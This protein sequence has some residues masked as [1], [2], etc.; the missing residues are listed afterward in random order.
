MKSL[1][2]TYNCWK[3]PMKTSVSHKT[4]FPHGQDITAST[5]SWTINNYNY[6]W[7]DCWCRFWLWQ[8]QHFRVLDSCSWAIDFGQKPPDP[9]WQWSAK[10]AFLHPA[11]T[12]WWVWLIWCFFENLVS[13]AL[14][15]HKSGWLELRCSHFSFFILNKTIKDGDIA[16]W[17]IWKKLYTWLYGKIWTKRKEKNSEIR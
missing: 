13:Q 2:E 10:K 3:S 8:Q 4:R 12:F 11:Y 14:N 6:G 15:L 5:S 16:S 17:S 1:H 9:D 7:S